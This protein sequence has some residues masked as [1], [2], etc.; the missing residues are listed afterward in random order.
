MPALIPLIATFAS[1]YLGVGVLSAT[2]IFYGVSAALYVGVAFGLQTLSNLLF[3]PKEVRPE[4]VQQSTRQSIT[5]RIKH[6]GYVLA[7]GPW[8]F[9]ATKGGNFFKVL[10][11][12]QGPIDSIIR[13][14]VDDNIAT[15]DGSG[16]VTSDPYGNYVNI[17][18]RLGLSTETSYSGLTSV[19]PEWTTDYRGDSVVSLFARQYALKAEWYPSTFPRGIETQ[20]RAEI[21]GSLMADVETGVVEWSDNPANIIKDYMTHD[22][23]QRLPSYLFETPEAESKMI[24]A[25]NI[26]NASIPLKAG[27]TEKRWRLWG[28]YRLDERPADVLGRMLLSCDGRIVITSDGGMALEVGDQVAPNFTLD[29]STITGVSDFGHGRNILTTANTIRATYLDP[30]NTYQTTDAD[31][32]VDDDDVDLRGEIVRDTS[33]IMAPSHSQCRRLMKIEAYRANPNWVATFFCNI[34]ALKVFGERYIYIDLPELGIDNEA[35]E[36]LDFRFDIGENGILRGAT[37]QAQSMP[38][39]AYTWDEDTEEGTAP[40]FDKIIEDSTIPVPTGFSVA[41]E[42]IY[43][44]VQPI[45]FARLTFDPP[46]NE[47]MRIV[48]RGKKVSDPTWTPIAIAEEATTALSFPLDDGIEYEF[49][50]RQE[51]LTG[52]ASLWTTSA[53]LTP[54]ADNVAPGA[55]S[56]VTVTGGLGSA[57]IAATAPASSNVAR[58]A[59]YR[60]ADGGTLNR[61]TDLVTKIP[62][63]PSGSISYTNGDSTPVNLLT[64]PDFATVLTP[65]TGA[66]WSVVSAKAK[67]TPGSANNL[68]QTVTLTTGQVVRLGGTVSGR[69]AGSTGLVLTG[70]TQ[71]TGTTVSVDGLYLRSLTANATTTG[72]GINTGSVFD[73][74]WDDIVAYVQTGSCAPQG[75]W[76]YHIEAEN[77]SAVP[78]T[79]SVNTNKVIY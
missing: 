59:I 28:S 27:G 17:Q 32:W 21:K 30:N 70:S 10:A 54:V 6:Y 37:I 51:S 63:G 48:A 60:Y 75:S 38:P 52:R 78:G 33:F 22:D 50:I 31:P 7:S 29:S 35:F 77:G 68:V 25:K 72:V 18:Y 13:F 34:K 43:A 57:T 49:Q 4:D 12:G 40:V 3:R 24:V 15:L 76:T 2:A 67:H 62:V 39:A 47:A 44:G 1:A 20:Y 64:N 58:I 74:S 55:L 41:V 46:V 11:L 69:T 42:R 9:G 56:A 73:G 66:G 36:I 26:S 71:V 23:G 79:A 8:V 19:F 61:T 16:F 45:A 65:W 5:A 14:Y 53:L